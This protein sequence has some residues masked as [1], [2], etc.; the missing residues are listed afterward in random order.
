M[1]DLFY[2]LQVFLIVAAEPHSSDEMGHNFVSLFRRYAQT[3]ESSGALVQNQNVKSVCVLMTN[4]RAIVDPFP[5]VSTNPSALLLT[6][7]Q[8]GYVRL[9][10]KKTSSGKRCIQ[11]LTKAKLD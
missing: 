6:D 7:V 10:E 3:L 8:S 5:S 1:E 9:L 4:Q 11:T 2:H